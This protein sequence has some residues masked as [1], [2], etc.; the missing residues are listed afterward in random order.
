M[1]LVIHIQM[2]YKKKKNEIVISYLLFLFNFNMQ[3]ECMLKKNCQTI[4]AS[5]VFEP[6]FRSV[7]MLVICSR[8]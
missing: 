5:F 3:L 8:G 6:A 2:S 1:L 4:F 7:S